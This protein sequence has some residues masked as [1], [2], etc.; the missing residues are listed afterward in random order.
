MANN[1][2]LF[3]AAALLGVFSMGAQAGYFKC[4]DKDG[5]VT[6]ASTRDECP[7]SKATEIEKGREV[8]KKEVA[9]PAG[10]PAKP[11]DMTPEQIEQKRHD[12]ALLGTYSSED[13]ID[14]A[15]K[16]NLQ[17]VDTRISNIQLQM[18]SVQ[19]DL[20]KYNKEKAERQVSGKPVDKF[21]QD[22]IALAN[23][24]MSRLQAD[25]T[26]AQAEKEAIKE[27]FA[28]DKKRYREL[29]ANPQ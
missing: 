10:G 1:K 22:E 25:Q 3:G 4:V 8:K 24:R 28:A 29:I 20:D 16:R 13:E 11:T 21:L 6:Y 23:A 18:K 9:R 2:F 17:Q 5:H 19:D 7:S 27:R 26:K 12:D 15:L 14:Q